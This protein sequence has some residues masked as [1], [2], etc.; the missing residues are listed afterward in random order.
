[1]YDL[2]MT[3]SYKVNM[4]NILIADDERDIV[5]ALKIYL[6]SEN[7]NLF[8][9]FNGKQALEIVAH[10]TIH[11]ILMDVMMPDMDGI[12]A[13]SR[14]REFSNI[15]VILLTAKSEDADKV[16]GLNSGADDYITK[17]FSPTEVQARV[18]SQLR[19]YTRLGGAERTPDTL[20]IGGVELNDET[21]QVTVD[22]D[23]VALT[24]TEYAILKLLMSNPGKV[25]SSAQIFTLVSGDAMFIS[26]SAVAVHIR[27]IREKI[28]IN[29]SDPRYLKVVWGQGYKVIDD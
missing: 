19:R 14:L 3:L 11:L 20:V 22:G 23:E 29:P 21:K 26:R 25:F 13:T 7:Y 4:T 18:R 16:E 8:E 10:E 24:P 27:H 15:P 12:K 2:A 5:N 1:M 28:E 9:A 6:R 17:P